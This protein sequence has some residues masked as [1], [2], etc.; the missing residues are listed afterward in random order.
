MNPNRPLG[1]PELFLIGETSLPGFLPAPARI[2][3]LAT[4]S[5]QPEAYCRHKRAIYPKPDDRFGLNQETDSGRLHDSSRRDFPPGER[6]TAL[7]G[8]QTRFIETT[9]IHPAKPVMN[10]PLW[11]REFSFPKS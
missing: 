3:L 4:P 6:K 8:T 7:H 10:P 2:L 9:L 5:T 11:F 1:S